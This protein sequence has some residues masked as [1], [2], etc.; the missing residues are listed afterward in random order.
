MTMFYDGFSNC[1][2]SVFKE[3]YSEL[4]VVCSN[5]FQNVDTARS[6]L[7][8]D[9]LW[10]SRWLSLDYRK[11][12]RMCDQITQEDERKAKLYPL[13]NILLGTS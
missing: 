2:S 5:S 12:G 10:Q 3:Q 8:T 9:Q 1:S 6:G 4:P 7:E 11:E 13:H